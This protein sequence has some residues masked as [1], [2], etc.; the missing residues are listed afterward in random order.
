MI[1]I[2]NS[3]NEP[4][5]DSKSRYP[6]QITNNENNKK[7]KNT[8]RKT[9]LIT[10]SE[11]IKNNFNKLILYIINKLMQ[12]T[13]NPYNGFKVD[14]YIL[15]ENE[16]QGE[17][18][19]SSTN[20][21]LSKISA[22]HNPQ[23]NIKSHDTDDIENLIRAQ[24][25][26]NEEDSLDYNRVVPVMDEMKKLSQDENDPPKKKWDQHF[27]I[28][29]RN[30]NTGW[31]RENDNT[32]LESLINNLTNTTLYTNKEKLGGGTNRQD[33]FQDIKAAQID[34][35]K[36][37][38]TYAYSSYDEDNL[39]NYKETEDLIKK[40]ISEFEDQYKKTSNYNKRVRIM[41]DLSTILFETKM[42]TFRSFTEN[43][44]E[45]IYALT[46]KK[47]VLTKE[48]GNNDRLKEMLE[49]KEKITQNLQTELNKLKRQEDENKEGIR[50]L[51]QSLIQHSH[52]QQR[53]SDNNEELIQENEILIEKNKR[54]T[55]ELDA[56]NEKII[57]MNSTIADMKEMI[58]ST[59]NEKIKGLTEKLD[60]ISAMN[61][62]YRTELEIIKMRLDVQNNAAKLL[63]E[64]NGMMGETIQ[65]QQEN[66][67]GIEEKLEKLKQMERD[68]QQ[69][70][71]ELNSNME[72]Y[73]KSCQTR[74]SELEKKNTELQKEIE[75]LQDKIINLESSKLQL[76]T[77]INTDQKEL[78]EQNKVLEESIDT[79]KDENR[80]LSDLNTDIQATNK[81][82]K[83]KLFRE[84]NENELLKKKKEECESEKDKIKAENQE[85]REDNERIKKENLGL[86]RTYNLKLG[87]KDNEMEKMQTKIEQLKADIPYRGTVKEMAKKIERND[88]RAVS[89]PRAAS[90]LPPLP[91]PSYAAAVASTRRQAWV[92]RPEDPIPEGKEKSVYSSYID[93]LINKNQALEFI[94]DEN[95]K[96]IKNYILEETARFFLQ[97]NIDK[98]NSIADPKTKLELAVALDIVL[99]ILKSTVIDTIKQKVKDMTDTKKTVPVKDV[100]NLNKILNTPKYINYFESSIYYILNVYSNSLSSNKQNKYTFSEDMRRFVDDETSRFFYD[101]I[102]FD[103]PLKGNNERPG[104]AYSPE[105]SR[106]V[107]KKRPNLSDNFTVSSSRMW[108]NIQKTVLYGTGTSGPSSE[109]VNFVVGI[110]L[111]IPPHISDMAFYFSKRLK[112]NSESMQN[113]RNFEMAAN[114]NRFLDTIK[115]E[116]LEELEGF[117]LGLRYFNKQTIRN[118]SKSIVSLD[119]NEQL[120]ADIQSIISKNAEI[121]KGGSSSKLVHSL[122]KGKTNKG[123]KT[124][125]NKTKRN[126]TTTT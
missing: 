90:S 5:G 9:P 6:I 67:I 61:E 101:M 86:K 64:T 112:K 82:E 109:I 23:R 99:Y 31:S 117:L 17:N 24:L 113:S 16:Q 57:E 118:F 33:I 52:E 10:D 28:V 7:K 15:F 58:Q 11:H 91:P 116:Y 55:R 73:E 121:S 29:N 19:N 25:A 119:E 114:T 3:T 39:V 27:H 38:K 48:K 45:K 111:S 71:D 125:R 75:G 37:F 81:R 100:S 41:T 97:K 80:L 62:K 60:Q 107:K 79:L 70:I 18:K 96:N 106:Y 76:E 21:T 47:D 13:K 69:K 44:M 26:I 85:I 49:N 98:L 50:K 51:E 126:K 102:S 78:S 2:L 89:S 1:N 32:V 66:F 59:E 115:S 123:N 46:K 110:I 65:M 53:L 12:Q 124:K 36:P 43:A 42:D 122:K 87:L 72:T 120:I 30:I 40:T 108:P 105:V 68:K 74:I 20:K 83:D 103:M 77:S 88:P 95:P 93:S 94:G 22:L 104:L 8:P 4:I 14:N 54:I 56:Q 84:R 34:D 92:E 35:I 63:S